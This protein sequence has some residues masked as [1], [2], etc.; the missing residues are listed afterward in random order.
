MCTEPW[1]RWMEAWPDRFVFSFLFFVSIVFKLK[2]FHLFFWEQ[3]NKNIHLWLPERKVPAMVMVF[4]LVHL[5]ETHVSLLLKGTCNNLIHR[6]KKTQI[7]GQREK[8][9]SPKGTPETFIPTS[10]TCHSAFTG[11]NTKCFAQSSEKNT[12]AII[13]HLDILNWIYFSAPDTCSL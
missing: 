11:D 9:W 1:W 7:E 3:R 6:P 13:A 4:K 12:A 8:I 2:N 10:E 5:T